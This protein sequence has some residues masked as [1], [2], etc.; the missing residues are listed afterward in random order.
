MPN[1][2]GNQQ[3]TNTPPSRCW[4]IPRTLGLRAK[5]NIALVPLVVAALS[6][7]VFLDYRHEFRSIMDAHGVHATRVA[8][9]KSAVPILVRA[10]PN[11]VAGRTIALH[12][13][14]GGVMLVLI[15]FG[16][17]LLL[18]RLVLMPIRRVRA[19]IEQLQRGFTA[20]DAPTDGDEISDVVAAFGD[21]GLTLD[22]MLLHALN[23]ERLATLALLS[24]TVASQIDPEIQRLTSAAMRLC[25]IQD[26]AV[27]DDGHEIAAATAN[28]LAVLRRLDRPFAERKHTAAA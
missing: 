28:I 19:G 13:V 11:A 24:K 5:F 27:L 18:S 15:V 12:L 4:L 6:L 16:V 22:A 3:T 9:V 14:V 7:L 10:T 26:D 8:T 2:A 20:R 23:T 21:L 25:Q 1:R 17:N